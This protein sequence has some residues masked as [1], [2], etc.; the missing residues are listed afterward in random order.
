MTANDGHIFDK[1]V[2]GMLDDGLTPKAIHESQ[3]NMRD[4]LERVMKE[5]DLPPIE[6]ALE[7]QGSGPT[8]TVRRP[9]RSML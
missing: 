5:R 9:T 8:V 2:R 6:E 1:A 3:P 7:Q 4:A